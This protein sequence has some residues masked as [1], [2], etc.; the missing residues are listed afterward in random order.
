MADMVYGER[1]EFD[2]AVGTVTA[3]MQMWLA[4]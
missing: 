4:S 3:V 1:P 2:E